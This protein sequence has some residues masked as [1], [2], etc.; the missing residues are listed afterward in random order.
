ML[1]LLGPYIGHES[2]LELDR[3]DR[4]MLSP[5]LQQLIERATRLYEEKLKAELET[6][7]LN[8]FVAIEPQSGEY[9]LGGT[10]SEARQAA[11]AAH[12]DRLTYLLR[13][14]HEAAVHIG[15]ASL[16][17]TARRS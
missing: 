8:W 9:F 16:S 11:R 14:G 4:R 2:R 10:M 7:H 17:M 6:S 3:G 13:V 12:P 5:E 15:S 1:E